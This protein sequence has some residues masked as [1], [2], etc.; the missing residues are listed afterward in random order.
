MTLTDIV[1][2]ALRA[3]TVLELL[4]SSS[5]G[6]YARYSRW[7]ARQPDV[8]NAMALRGV[9]SVEILNMA[10]DTWRFL[11]QQRHRDEREVD[12]AILLAILSDSADQRVDEFLLRVGMVDRP[13][14]SWVSALA[15]LLSFQRSASEIARHLVRLSWASYSVLSTIQIR[16][17]PGY[18]AERSFSVA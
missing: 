12:L 4:A 3:R 9:S 16:Q 18:V 6:R 15:R 7:V 5:L 10:Q 2:E 14:L 1:P 8:R 17:D 11:A 13:P